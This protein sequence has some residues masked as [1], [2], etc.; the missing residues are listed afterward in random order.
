[1]ELR[2]Q[3]DAS[4]KLE[5]F[6]NL[7]NIEYEIMD[8]ALVDDTLSGNVKIS[9]EYIKDEIEQNYAFDKVEP[10]TVIFKNANY[11]INDL[12]I[13][14]FVS[15]EIINNGV[16][17][18]S[19]LVINYSEQEV[20]EEVI[21][22]EK[23]KVDEE[24]DDKFNVEMVEKDEAEIV[25]KDD[26][27]EDAEIKDIEIPEIDQ[28]DI[29]KEDLIQKAKEEITKKYDDLLQKILE[30]REDNFLD[31]V[32]ENSNVEI[33]HKEDSCRNMNFS[34]IEEKYVTY[35]IFYPQRENEIESICQKERI[36]LDK[37]YKDNSTTDFINKR[38]IIIK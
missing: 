26:E 10:F 19:S 15:N 8:S 13:D 22:E 28:S 14:D 11:K 25:E 23:P 30:T 29:D 16:E 27:V 17:C 12:S 2:I 6:V 31:E 4:I 36:S 24:I 38:R 34:K 5:G 32:T 18:T 20:Q 21:E 37:I 33:I 9:G 3:C 7:I 35:K 1:M